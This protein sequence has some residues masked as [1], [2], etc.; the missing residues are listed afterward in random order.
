MKDAMDM[1]GVATLIANGHP[2]IALHVWSNL[3]T[4][5]RE[6]ALDILP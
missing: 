1:L 6:V 2:R 4:N 3:D 5:I